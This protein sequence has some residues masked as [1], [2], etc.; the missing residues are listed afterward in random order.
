[1]SPFIEC[2]LP[3]VLEDPSNGGDHLI[4]FG[5]FEDEVFLPALVRE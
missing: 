4:E 3:G 5:N 1:M 2:L